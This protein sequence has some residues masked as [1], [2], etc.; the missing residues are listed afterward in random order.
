MPYIEAV[1]YYEAITTIEAQEMLLDMTVVS[2][3]KMKDRD[4][5]KLHKD[6]H[7]KAYPEQ[8]EKTIS[9]A[10]FAQRAKDGFR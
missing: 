6:I 10:E 3:P 5:S 8:E 7:S 9:F 1:Q 2:Y 4:R